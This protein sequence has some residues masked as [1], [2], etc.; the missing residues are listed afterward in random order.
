MWGVRSANTSLG[1]IEFYETQQGLLE[2]L[3]NKKANALKAI[4][5]WQAAK[6]AS[7]LS[8]EREKQLQT[9]LNIVEDKREVGVIEPLDAELVYLNLTQVFNQISEYQAALKDA[10][11]KVKELLPDWSPEL[12]EGL[13]FAFNIENYSFRKEWIELHPLVRLA[14]AQWHKQKLKAELTSINTK[15]NPNI[16]INIGKNN[17][18]NIVGLEFSM[19][20][21]IRNNYFDS[22]RAANQEVI[23]AEAKY[24]SI[25][26]K[27]FFDAQAKLE[28]LLTNKKYL[29]RWQNLMQN[30]LDNSLDLL[31]ARWK[32]GDISTSDY[33][34]AFSQRTEGL[35]SGIQLK[36]KFKLS[37][38]SFVRSIGQISKF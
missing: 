17:D 21:N 11:V 9:L 33:L 5:I 31:N 24:Q 13:S 15:A 7:Q 18:E 28:V 10:E 23:A 12:Q 34:I 4:I 14:K 6:E 3:A 27:Q 20:L 35:L 30:R 19:P 26:R 38:I 16:G 8:T 22:I 2:L 29:G 25:Y 32:A 37:E 1:E 36:K